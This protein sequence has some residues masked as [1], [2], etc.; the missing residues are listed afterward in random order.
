MYRIFCL[1]TEAPSTP[2][3]PVDGYD[4][5]CPPPAGTV[6]TTRNGTVRV[7]TDRRVPPPDGRRCWVWTVPVPATVVAPMGIEPAEEFG[8]VGA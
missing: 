4:G 6:L 7:A 3:M 8:Q 2:P 5:P 1:S